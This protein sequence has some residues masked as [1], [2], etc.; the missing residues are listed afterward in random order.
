[1]QR[2]QSYEQPEPVYDNNAYTITSSF[3]GEHF[4]MY[5]THPTKPTNPRG[6][7]EYHMNQLRSFAMTGSA[8]SFRQGA[9]VYRNGR[10]WTKKKRDEFIEAANR[11]VTS[12]PQNMSFKSSDYSEPSTS[13]NR[14]AALES[15]TS[16][17]KLALDHETITRRSSKRP[18]G[19]QPER[20]DR[21][22]RSGRR[23]RPQRRG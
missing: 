15:D 21:E 13:T 2:L 20:N 10:D 4:H 14:A 5:T 16:A 3:D 6:R 8:E 17:N 23:D 19:G 18:K 11:R 7:P 12:L 9:T 22:Y 1:M